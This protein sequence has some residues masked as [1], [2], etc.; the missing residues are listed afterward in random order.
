MALRRLKQEDWCEFHGSLSYVAL[1]PVPLQ[2]ELENETISQGAKL[3]G[4]EQ[5]NAKTD[6]LLRSL[7]TMGGIR[8]EQNVS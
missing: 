4:T 5:L 7:V 6:D 8:I 2:L 3:L 1:L